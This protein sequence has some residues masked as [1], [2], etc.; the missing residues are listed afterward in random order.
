MRPSPL[1][2]Y[3]RRSS[4][5]NGTNVGPRRTTAV[6]EA[7]KPGK[8]RPLPLP[9]GCIVSKRD[10]LETTWGTPFLFACLPGLGRTSKIT[11]RYYCTLAKIT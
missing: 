11:F 3:R 6:E 9:P 7:K 5:L 10:P 8:A 4:A 1:I 2:P